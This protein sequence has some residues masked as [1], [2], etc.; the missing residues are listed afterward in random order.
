MG[1]TPGGSFSSNTKIE[2]EHLKSA[3]RGRHGS[4]WQ[5]C[6][7]Y[8]PRVTHQSHDRDRRVKKNSPHFN[9]STPRCSHFLGHAPTP[10]A[11][12]QGAPLKWRKC[13]VSWGPK[14]ERWLWHAIH[15]HT[16]RVLAYMVG[17]RKEAV[18]LKLRAAPASVPPPGRAH[19]RHGVGI[20]ALPNLSQMLYSSS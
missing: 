2:A 9:T 17:T 14:R 8:R 7:R 18:F 5:R 13:G 10:F 15:H 4:Q 12:D 16:G 19:R 6:A 20:P 1:S 3:A 11:S